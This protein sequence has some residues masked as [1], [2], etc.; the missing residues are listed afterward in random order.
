MEVL[1]R[2]SWLN[3]F[4]L[5]ILF[6]C[7]GNEKDQKEKE[8]K[9]KNF[10]LRKLLISEIMDQ[11]E[12]IERKMPERL[13]KANSN[14]FRNHSFNEGG[15]VPVFS[16]SIATLKSYLEENDY[17]L[18]YFDKL[19]GKFPYLNDFQSLVYDSYTIKKKG[20]TV[21]ILWHLHG[22][23]DVNQVNAFNDA[24]FELR[25]VKKFD[26][27][28]KRFKYWGYLNPKDAVLI[29]AGEDLK[30]KEPDL[31]G[32][33]YHHFKVRKYVVRG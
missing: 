18:V 6:A 25:G 28:Y 8:S 29:Q 27:H 1:S 14:V 16:E 32:I 23:E 15:E 3:I 26:Q 2:N 33:L 22:F 9:T 4:L 30:E 12:G 19:V 13:E 5:L 11:D 31:F 7:S 10:E 24:I 20:K 17:E 21:L